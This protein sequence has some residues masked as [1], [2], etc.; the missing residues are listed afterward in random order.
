MSYRLT[1]K[2]RPRQR[3]R[4]GLDVGADDA[5]H[6]LRSAVIAD[7]E[8]W[9]VLVA[10]AG[11]LGCTP[12]QRVKMYQGPDLQP[13]AATIS[14]SYDRAM[15]TLETVDGVIV[16]NQG[17]VRGGFANRKTTVLVQPGLHSVEIEFWAQGG[18]I[19]VTQPIPILFVAEGGHDY[20]IRE[21]RDPVDADTFLRSM[22]AAVAG[23]CQCW[24]LYVYDLTTGTLVRFRRPGDLPDDEMLAAPF[25]QRVL[26]SSSPLLPL[27][28]YML[29]NEPGVVDPAACPECSN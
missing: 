21:E 9:L 17:T 11:S 15:V 26:V 25:R 20:E 7:F 10:V 16:P 27:G 1:A 5:P 28:L 12:P 19:E 8:P 4:R 22:R 18:H 14:G 6:V 23:G 29:A 2:I 13:E 3:C 24:R